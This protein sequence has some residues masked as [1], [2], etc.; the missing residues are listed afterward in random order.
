MRLRWPVPRL[1][2]MLHQVPSVAEGR[3]ETRT[4]GSILIP[5]NASGYSMADLGISDI[6]TRT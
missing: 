4:F 3:D 6:V 1:P 5:F 2:Y